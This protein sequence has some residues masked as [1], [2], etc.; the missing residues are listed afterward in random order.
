MM[1]RPPQSEDDELAVLRE[2]IRAAGLRCTGPRVSVRRAMTRRASPVTHG[3]LAAAL[4]P[5]GLDRATVFRNLTDLAE[6]GMLSRTDLGDHVWRF[7]LKEEAEASHGK[8]HVHFVCRDCGTVSCLPSE[9]MPVAPL[10]VG[11]VEEILL[12]GLCNACN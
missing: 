4:G 6:A 12:K 11:R 2:R 3:E 8:D 1:S 9:T 10:A 5:A 7:E